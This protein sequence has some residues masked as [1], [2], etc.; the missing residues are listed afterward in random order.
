M[1]PEK[2]GQPAFFEKTP[3]KVAVPVFPRILPAVDDPVGDVR[4]AVAAGVSSGIS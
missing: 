2:R 4:S 3:K 1:G